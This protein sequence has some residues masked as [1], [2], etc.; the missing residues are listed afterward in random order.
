MKGSVCQIPRW[1]KVA[2]L[3]SCNPKSSAFQPSR[4]HPKGMQTPTK[5][6]TLADGMGQQP[7][8]GGGPVVQWNQNHIFSPF[9]FEVLLLKL[10]TEN[11]PGAK[12]YIILRLTHYMSSSKKCQMQKEQRCSIDFN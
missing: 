5:I 2:N 9:T 7:T 12:D 4:R 3:C 6:K 10:N 11:Q 8:G 1:S